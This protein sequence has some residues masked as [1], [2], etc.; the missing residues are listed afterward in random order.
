MPVESAK[1]PATRHA[2]WRAAAKRRESLM[3]DNPAGAKMPP[4]RRDGLSLAGWVTVTLTS[5]E[6]PKLAD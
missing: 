3:A 4:V 2:A 5:T 6:V 1:W